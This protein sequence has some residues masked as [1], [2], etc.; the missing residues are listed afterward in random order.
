MLW[1]IDAHGIE[2][3]NESKVSDIVN[4]ERNPALRDVVNSKILLD[5]LMKQNFLCMVDDRNCF[6]GIITRKDIIMYLEEQ[7]EKKYTK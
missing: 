2:R 4:T 3:I 7:I 1:Y 6:I 5:S